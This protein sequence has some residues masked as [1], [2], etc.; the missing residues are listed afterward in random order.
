MQ[1][2]MEACNKDQ[3]FTVKGLIQLDPD[4]LLLI[5]KEL[6]ELA[7]SEPVPPGEPPSPA[8]TS[9]APHG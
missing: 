9:P 4:F 3:M 2:H 7:G 6:L 5:A 1:V 8:L